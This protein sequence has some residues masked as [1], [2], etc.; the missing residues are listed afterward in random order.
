MRI[1]IVSDV[2][3]NIEALSAVDLAELPFD[4]VFCNG[5]IRLQS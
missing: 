3:T 5:D 4:H 2:H 1:L